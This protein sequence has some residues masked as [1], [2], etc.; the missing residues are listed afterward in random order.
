MN[1]NPANVPNV[2]KDI[3]LGREIEK[4]V[5]SKEKKPALNK[6]CLNLSEFKRI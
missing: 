3:V 2:Y 1:E 6:K 4:K 5:K